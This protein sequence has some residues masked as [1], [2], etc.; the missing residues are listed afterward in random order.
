MEGMIR[1]SMVLGMVLAFSMT[2][3]IVLFLY[4]RNITRK[5]ARI[6]NEIA[7]LRDA[8]TSFASHV[9][10]V[11]ELEMFYGDQTLQ[12]LM[13]H[14]RSFRDYMEEFDYIYIIEEQEQDDQEKE[15]EV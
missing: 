10:S 15:E 12:S 5:L 4:S 9:K 14:A 6:G 1:I 2:V 13:D 7:D 3:N 11:Y 8:I